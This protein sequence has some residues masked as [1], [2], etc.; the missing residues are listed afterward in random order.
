[1]LKLVEPTME[2]EAQVMAYKDA[3]LRNGDFLDGCGGLEDVERYADWL[4]FEERGI[5]KIGKENYV[6]ST[7]YLAVRREDGKVVGMIELR[8]RLTPHLLQFGGHIGYSILP[9]E[10]RKGYAKEMLGLMLDLCKERGMDRVLL[11]CNKTNIG[12]AKTIRAN[13][14]VLEN[15]VPRTAGHDPGGLTQRYWIDLAGRT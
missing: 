3:F 5:Q 4:K 13:G 6:P 9:S 1:M 14:G 2:H 15:E 7:L 10:R 11:T 12:S 8:H